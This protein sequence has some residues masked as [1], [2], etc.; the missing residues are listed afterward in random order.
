MDNLT[1]TI[2]QYV[3]GDSWIYKLD[4]RFKIISFIIL[5][6]ALFMLPTLT[7]MLGALIVLIIILL[8]ARLPIGL[9][10]K[11]LKPIIIISLFSFCLQIIYT[12]TG[13]LIYTKLVN[14]SLFHILTMIGIF[15]FYIFTSKYIKFKMSYLLITII[16]ILSSLLYIE[17]SNVVITSFRF[18]IYD[19]GLIKGGF[20][21]SRIVLLVIISTILTLTTS[22]IDLNTGLEK[23]LSP[24]KLIK[25]PVAEISLMISLTLRFVPT[26]LLETN[27]ILKAQ[28]SRGVD[29]SEGS[30][31]QK[32][33]QIIT[34][35]IPMFVVSFKRAEDLA[36]A[37]EA[38]GYVI[39]SKRSNLNVLK[40]KF[41]DY[42]GFLL[43]FG[44]LGLSIYLQVTL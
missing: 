20:F 15:T 25:L 41:I 21:V 9:I 7:Y 3:K 6:I 26:L 34:L 19:D 32:V 13:E 2:G 24:F 11:G 29:F 27:K 31:V 5:M 44:V 43:I 35:L 37:M 1:L 14:F 22:T 8:S 4:P 17:F 12:Q 40:F 18:N 38:R 16:A 39:G 42:L 36:C 10:I 23:V 28:A 33:K 30:I